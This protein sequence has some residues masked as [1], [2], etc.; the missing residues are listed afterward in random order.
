MTVVR[1]S[2]NFFPITNKYSN[3]V[4]MTSLRRFYGWHVDAVAGHESFEQKQL[5]YYLGDTVMNAYCIPDLPLNIV[6]L[7]ISVKV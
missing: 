5:Q 2:S 7:Y 6:S 1:Q 3:K 4:P